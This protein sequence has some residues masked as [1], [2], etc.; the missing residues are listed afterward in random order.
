MP[1]RDDYP[2]MSDIERRLTTIFNVKDDLDGNFK[3]FISF[4]PDV[5][6]Q[7]LTEKDLHRETAALCQRLQKIEDLSKYSA[8]T[9]DWWLNHRIV[10]YKRLIG[11]M[12]ESQN[13]GEFLFGLSPY[14]S[15]LLL[16]NH[17]LEEYMDYYLGLN[18]DIIKQN[19]EWK[20]QNFEG[21]NYF[22]GIIKNI[23][24]F[25]IFCELAYLKLR[26]SPK[27]YSGFFTILE[28]AMIRWEKEL[29]ETYSDWISPEEMQ[30]F[31]RIHDRFLTLTN[32][33]K[34]IK[35]YDGSISKEDQAKLRKSSKE[36]LLKLEEIIHKLKNQI[37]SR[38]RL[39]ISAL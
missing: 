32:R 33:K 31:T 10:D 4:R 13:P 3:K 35:I 21:E 36:E 23:A 14:E 39:N 12:V 1:C 18:K 6:D 29:G 17:L 22:N 11:E 9:I 16:N 8:Y 30:V 24:R 7:G 20:R 15:D 25:N 28:D 19:E 34:G 38:V 26:P 2:Q 27:D 37:L 5:L